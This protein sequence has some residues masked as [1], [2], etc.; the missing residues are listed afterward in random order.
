[1]R[2]QWE[3]ERERERDRERERERASEKATQRLFSFELSLT[4]KSPF[5][6]S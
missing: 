5:I 1:M 4:E 2:F 3:R 6:A